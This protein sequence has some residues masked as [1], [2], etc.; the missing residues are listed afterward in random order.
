MALTL[1]LSSSLVR[2][3]FKA[4]PNVWQE[5]AESWVLSA[6]EIVFTWKHFCCSA[7]WKQL[8]WNQ[9]MIN[10]RRT[11]SCCSDSHSPNWMKF[12]EFG[13]KSNKMF[14]YTKKVQMIHWSW[15]LFSFS[16]FISSSSVWQEEETE[17]CFSLQGRLT[18]SS[19]K[20]FCKLHFHPHQ[21]NTWR[22]SRTAQVEDCWATSSPVHLSIQPSVSDYHSR[23]PSNPI[24][25]RSRGAV[26][27]KHVSARANWQKEPPDRLKQRRSL[28][29]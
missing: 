26:I 6:H 22:L 19:Q 15:P 13:L 1:T 12:S 14:V 10:V 16:S 9:K 11:A 21:R 27:A 7:R 17:L 28:I 25:Y 3:R 5:A 24:K 20:C 29:C 23:L 2:S 18:L 4:Q 8:V